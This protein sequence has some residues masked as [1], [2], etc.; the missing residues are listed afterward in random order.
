[1]SS[2]ISPNW[3]LGAGRRKLVAARRPAPVSRADG[4]RLYEPRGCSAGILISAKPIKVKVEASA[5]AAFWEAADRRKAGV[6]PGRI[7]SSPAGRAAIS[8]E[9]GRIA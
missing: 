5:I 9:G 1:M 3:T 7:P 2:N 4:S 6:E 8:E